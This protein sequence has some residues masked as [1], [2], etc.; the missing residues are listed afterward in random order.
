MSKNGFP[1][2]TLAEVNAI[3]EQWK[4][5]HRHWHCL[6]HMLVLMQNINSDPDL[7]ESDRE[8]LH[9]V[10]LFHDAIYAPLKSDNEEKSAQ[11]AAYYLHKYPRRDEV[12]AAILATKTHQS[13]TEL[14]KKFNAWDCAILRETNWD[15]LC[16]YER[17][18]A[19][20][21]REVGRIT[22]RRERAKFLRQAALDYE[23]PVLAELADAVEAG[24][25]QK[26]WVAGKKPAWR[27]LE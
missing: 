8:M 3:I 4:E 15:K 27:S 21:F 6:G 5:P 24:P 14:E 13:K 18:I 22:Y 2:L 12:V 11:M 25:H 17:C 1:A 9:Y 26:H 16:H 23:N 7:T 20:E 19:E 10:A